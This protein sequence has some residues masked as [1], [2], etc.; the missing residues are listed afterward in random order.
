MLAYVSL[1]DIPDNGFTYW[2]CS[3]LSGE[4]EAADSEKD[5]CMTLS[6]VQNPI[7]LLRVARLAVKV[8][9]QDQTLVFFNLLEKVA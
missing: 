2:D 4:C 3:Q 5:L 6:S 9:N 8:R 1:T 7:E